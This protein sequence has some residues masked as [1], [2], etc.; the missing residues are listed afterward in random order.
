M[1]E[2][3]KDTTRA[4]N[5]Y[6]KLVPDFDYMKSLKTW[7]LILFLGVSVRWLLVGLNSLNLEKAKRCDQTFGV[8]KVVGSS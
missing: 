7:V 2:R 6:V 1:V 5:F 4:V 8:R 3:V